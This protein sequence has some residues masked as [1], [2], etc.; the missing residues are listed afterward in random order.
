MRMCSLLVATAMWVGVPGGPRKR[1]SV[2]WSLLP[3][4]WRARVSSGA[5]SCSAATRSGATSGPQCRARVS[6]QQSY[7]VQ[8]K[9]QGSRGCGRI[10][11]R[12]IH[13]LA[14]SSSLRGAAAGFD[15]QWPAHPRN[16]AHQAAR[17]GRERKQQASISHQSGIVADVLLPQMGGKLS[18]A[19]ECIL[20]QMPRRQGTLVE[21]SML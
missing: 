5:E 6:V 16:T 4:S 2:I 7:V 12:S 8:H 21:N 20:Q 10:G 14:G 17:Y 18:Q 19:Q 3:M 15:D 13:F 11:L 1:T 9:Q